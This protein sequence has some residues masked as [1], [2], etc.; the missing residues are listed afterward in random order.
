MKVCALQ[1]TNTE[2]FLC[3]IKFNFI[4]ESMWHHTYFLLF[5]SMVLCGDKACAKYIY[6]FIKPYTHV[7]LMCPSNYQASRMVG[8]RYLEG[9]YIIDSLPVFWISPGESL[10]T[11]KLWQFGLVGE[12]KCQICG[13]DAMLH[14]TQ[15][16]LVL[17][18]AQ[19][20][21]DVVTLL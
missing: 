10:L 20:A 13:Q 12:E 11:S 15:H 19:L 14:I 7:N 16:L 6:I 1:E 18:A 3:I 17:P 4:N 9:S 21:E 2:L 8:N 5:T